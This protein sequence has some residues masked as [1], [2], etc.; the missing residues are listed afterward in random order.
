MICK[1]REKYETNQ[2]K[3]RKSAIYSYLRNTISLNESTFEEM[4]KNSEIDLM[5]LFFNSRRDNEYY[6]LIYKLKFVE[7]H[8]IRL[9][10]MA[11]HYNQIAWRFAEFLM[12]SVKI[13]IFDIF[14]FNQPEIIEVIIFFSKFLDYYKA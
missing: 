3:L 4:R 10:S 11:A 2:K 7:F 8:I 1:K 6:F 13:A 12:N 14:Y 5:I 9:T